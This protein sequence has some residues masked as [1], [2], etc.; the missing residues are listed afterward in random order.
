[1]VCQVVEQVADQSHSAGLGGLGWYA[2]PGDVAEDRVATFNSVFRDWGKTVR[3][4]TSTFWM[5]SCHLMPSIC[6]RHF[7]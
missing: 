5:W 7:M 3:F 6:R 2:N 4:P 1:M